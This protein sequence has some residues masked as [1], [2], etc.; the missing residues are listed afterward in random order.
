M[1]R[2]A[3]AQS[4]TQPNG[5][6]LAR[7]DRSTRA[8][9]VLLNQAIVLHDGKHYSDALAVVDRALRLPAGADLTSR[10]WIQRSRVLQDLD[11]LEEALEAADRSVADAPEFPPAWDQRATNLA[12]LKRDDEAL[13]AVERAVVLDPS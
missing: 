1:S 9:A 2:Q 3:N 12:A 11:R 4:N 8:A 5:Q 7:E 6:S 13:D 10:L